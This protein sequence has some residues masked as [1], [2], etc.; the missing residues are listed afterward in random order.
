M[1]MQETNPV[2]PSVKDAGHKNILSL[3]VA[4]DENNLIGDNNKLPWHL[5]D[6]LKYF[7]N[8]T[9]AM[10]VI[11]GRK[12]FES[13][14]KPLPGRQNIVI[15]RNAGWKHEGV[16]VVH[17]ID[18]AIGLAMKRNV[19]EVFIIGGAEIFKTSFEKADR[20]YMTRIH[21]KF[22]GDVYFPAINELQ[23]KLTKEV[24]RAPDEKNAYAHSFQVWERRARILE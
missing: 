15:T 10:P 21:H 22:E 4:A 12:T 2:D 8:I 16:D 18:E 3:L 13:V 1:L 5:P 19:L 20:I 9:W 17:H 24:F 23:W 6:D 11:M 14:G 7:K